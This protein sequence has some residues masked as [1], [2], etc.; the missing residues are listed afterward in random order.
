MY[1]CTPLKTP[2]IWLVLALNVKDDTL[3]IFGKNIA[4]ERKIWI[5]MGITCVFYKK[6]VNLHTQK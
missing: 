3:Y 4:L 6:F 5:I 2:F 1:M